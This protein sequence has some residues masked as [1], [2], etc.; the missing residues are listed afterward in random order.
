MQVFLGATKYKHDIMVRLSVQSESLKERFRIGRPPKLNCL[1]E[2]SFNFT[3]TQTTNAAR[4]WV[5]VSM[6]PASRFPTF[7]MQPKYHSLP[8][9][10]KKDSKLD[11]TTFE[12]ERKS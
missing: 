2:G 11:A 12:P 3:Q 10:E 4:N 6:T 1:P 7:G 5:Q 8:P 9:L